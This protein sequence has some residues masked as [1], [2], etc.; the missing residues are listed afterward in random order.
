MC[1][2]WVAVIFL[3][4]TDEILGCDIQMKAVEYSFP[5]DLVY[6][7]IKGDSKV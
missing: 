4:T 7:A 1:V 2:Y 6:Y 5:V 3:V